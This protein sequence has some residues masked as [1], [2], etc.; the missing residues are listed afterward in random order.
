MSLFSY[1]DGSRRES[2]LSVLRDVSPIAANW[3]TTRLGVSEAKNT[4]HEWVTDEIDRPTSTNFQ[5]E[6]ADWTDEDN[7]QP[8]RSSNFTAIISRAVRLSG[9]Q[10]AI[11]VALPGDP[12]DFQKAKSL[13]KLKADMEYA[14]VN[15]NAKASGSSGTARDMAGLVG[16]ISTNVTARA[17][18]TSMSVQEIED[19]HQE[20]WEKASDENLAD[21]LLV[22]MGLKRKIATFS[23]RITHNVDSTSTI[24]NNVSNFETSS[25]MLKIVPHRDVNR[26]AGTVHALMIREDTY[27]MAFLTG[28][29]PMWE[30]IAKVG[31]ADRGQYIC[32]LTLESLAQPASVKRSGYATLG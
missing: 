24:H 22:P 10:R 20:S 16:V 27:K 7:P 31:D 26:A 17:S 15:G 6:G 11:N 14:L 8:V 1:D 23:T 3:L 18:G 25:G 32:E 30:D 19:M 9:T 4:L 5:A 2:L 12:F 28:R 21:V 13:K 29:Q